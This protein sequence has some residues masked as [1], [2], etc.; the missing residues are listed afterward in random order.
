MWSMKM[1]I[2]DSPRKKSRRR[3]RCVD[4]SGTDR[5]NSRQ[6]ATPGYSRAAP[7]ENSR[8]GT[9]GRPGLPAIAAGKSPPAN[10]GGR[11][12]AGGMAHFLEHL[13]RPLEGW[14][15]DLGSQ[16]MTPEVRRALTGGVAAEAG[17]RDIAALEAQ[18]DRFLLGLLAPKKVADSE[19]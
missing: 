2:S 12:G 18:R 13:G 19:N 15:D 10:T 5:L 6:A 8:P 14:W 4:G 11:R 1:K 3:S 7:P 17:Y 16:S 9:A